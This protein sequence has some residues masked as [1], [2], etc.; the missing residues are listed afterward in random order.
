MYAAIEAVLF[1]PF[2]ANFGCSSNMA[3]IFM[4]GKCV[5]VGGPLGRFWD[6][7]IHHFERGLEA[8]VGVHLGQVGRM[9]S[10]ELFFGSRDCAIRC[11]AA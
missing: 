6:P 11:R 10:S 1:W 4:T 2:L 9:S 3:W 7:G 5:F 8:F